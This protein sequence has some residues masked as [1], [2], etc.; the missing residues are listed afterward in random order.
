MIMK[1]WKNAQK[2]Y[3][4]LG[5]SRRSWRTPMITL[6][7]PL[8]IS[9]RKWWNLHVE[10]YWRKPRSGR[11]P[12]NPK[13]WLLIPNLVNFLIRFI[14][15]GE[16]N[17]CRIYPKARSY[18]IHIC[19]Y[20]SKQAGECSCNLSLDKIKN[21]ED[22][23]IKTNQPNVRVDFNFRAAFFLSFIIIQY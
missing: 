10:F 8:E 16:M 14:L 9:E 19:T 4:Y 22:Q 1:R 6:S 3:M 18:I 2:I 12:E 15:R 21:V 5:K 11:G 17:H 13:W 7:N 20:I 23:P